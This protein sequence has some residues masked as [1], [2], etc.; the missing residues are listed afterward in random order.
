[1]I[2]EIALL[3]WIT[4]GLRWSM[5]RT[6]F[7]QILKHILS[8]VSQRE[9]SHERVGSRWPLPLNTSPQWPVR[10]HSVGPGAAISLSPWLRPRLPGSDPD[11]RVAVCGAR[12]PASWSDSWSKLYGIGRCC[13]CRPR[14]SVSRLISFMWTI[15]SHCLINGSLMV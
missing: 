8:T 12:R 3:S 4:T 2:L 14:S 1:M 7:L 5:T 6:L 11:P 9:N 13:Q 15:G 10:P